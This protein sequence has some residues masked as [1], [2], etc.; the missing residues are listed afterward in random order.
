MNAQ[1]TPEQWKEIE[2]AAKIS[3][4]ADLIVELMNHT[5]LP[6]ETIVGEHSAVKGLTKIK[7]KK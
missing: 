6:Y 3:E 7:L 5:G 1:L 2:M 4:I